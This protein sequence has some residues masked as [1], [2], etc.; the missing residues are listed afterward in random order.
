[1]PSKIRRGGRLRRRCSRSLRHAHAAE[2]DARL[3]RDATSPTIVHSIEPD[4]VKP[5]VVS[6]LNGACR[7]LVESGSPTGEGVKT[8][9][10]EDCIAMDAA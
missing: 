9:R 3:L 1:M 2:T 4:I 10:L 7:H 6:T 5:I 8:K